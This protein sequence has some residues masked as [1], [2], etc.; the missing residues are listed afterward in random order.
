MIG[1][2]NRADETMTNI[3]SHVE[4]I[5]DSIDE[6][7]QLSILE[8]M[9]QRTVQRALKEH[10]GELQHMDELQW[11][12]EGGV[13]T[14]RITEDVTNGESGESS[15]THRENDPGRTTNCDS[16]TIT[17]RGKTIYKT[18]FRCRLFDIDITTSDIEYKHRGD[19]SD[20]TP[21][22]TQTKRITKYDFRMRTFSWRLGLTYRSGNPATFYDPGL[23]PSF[24]TYNIV[25]NDAPIIK[26]CEQ[27][28]YLEVRRL[29]E[30]GLASP[31]D[32][33]Q[34]GY[35][36][37]NL[38]ILELW[39]Y[40]VKDANKLANAIYL[41]KLLV[42]CLGGELGQ[43]RSL[44]TALDQT[45][46]TTKV[47]T[48]ASY[49]EAL[50]LLIMHTSE[51]PFEHD[52][53]HVVRYT[54]LDF[55]QT[56]VYK[57]IVGQQKWWIDL[58]PRTLN[59]E[60]FE[61]HFV[62]NDLMM[63][64]DIPGQSLKTALSE[65]LLYLPYSDFTVDW[66]NYEKWMHSPLHFVLLFAS[67]ARELEQDTIRECCANRL[68]TLLRSSCDPWSQF[69]CD[70]RLFFTIWPRKLL[71]VT[72]FAKACNVLDLWESSLKL[73]GW[74]PSDIQHLFD[75][76]TYAGI[77][78]L[79]EERLNY[80]SMD[81]QQRDFIEALRCGAFVVLEAKETEILCRSKLSYELNFYPLEIETMVK[82]VA[83]I[84]QQRST[85]GSWL[86]EEEPRLIPGVDFKLSRGME[87][88]T[89]I[90]EIWD[91]ELGYIP[92]RR[93]RYGMSYYE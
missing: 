88:W 89:C 26:A 59:P 37:V 47:D 42:D 85:P 69:R 15:E 93:Q 56:P 20:W 68:T 46:R 53:N 36:L 7:P 25:P 50:R 3:L 86:E 48:L 77:P 75:E 72:E 5:K 31:L 55:T 57:V 39:H 8:S 11:Q 52:Y 82:E 65:G 78:E 79:F 90:R 62:E 71:S 66:K 23:C 6:L 80:T 60:A 41:L 61:G 24:R 13:T 16:Q 54:D 67:E 19:T 74:S 35:S 45:Q 49:A 44:Y 84:I 10:N 34:Y 21:T 51:D 38:I 18:S 91:N 58:D 17:R 70:M 9:I 33:N 27:L 14:S 29:F 83:S 40:E 32:Q 63:V 28:D 76:D 81:E 30:A 43:L 1:W 4:E 2:T 22:H 73:A 64:K 12:D 87:L 92:H